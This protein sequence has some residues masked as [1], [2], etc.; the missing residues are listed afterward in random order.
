MHF[1]VTDNLAS[2]SQG[3]TMALFSQFESEQAYKICMRHPEFE[4][5]W[6]DRIEPV[7]G[8]RI[9]AEGME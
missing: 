9:V 4:R 1:T 8:D 3:Y 6:R 7:I 5:V 2:Q